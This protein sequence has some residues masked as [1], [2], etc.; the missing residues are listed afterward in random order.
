MFH[1]CVFA[2]QFDL[3]DCKIFWAHGKFETSKASNKLNTINL[4]DLTCILQ[5]LIILYFWTLV[6][7]IF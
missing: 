7:I 4:I 5:F 1:F 3:C 2:F 6:N